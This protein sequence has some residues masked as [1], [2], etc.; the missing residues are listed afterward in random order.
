MPPLSI[1]PMPGRCWCWRGR[2]L[3]MSW[4]GSARLICAIM[5]SSAAMWPGPRWRIWPGRLRAW[6]MRT[7]GSWCFAGWPGRWST[8]RR[9]RCDGSRRGEIPRC[10]TLTGRAISPRYVHSRK[11]ETAMR[12]ML[13][14]ALSTLPLSA[15]A[16][17]PMCAPTGEI[18]A[19]AVEARKDG[20]EAPEAITAISADMT[21]GMAP[22]EP[23]VQPLVDWVYTL[24]EAELSKDVEGSYVMQCEAQ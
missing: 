17:N 5:G 6:G 13:I 22:Y 2:G 7:G 10:E 14:A 24:D 21:G 16:Q 20:Q 9:W 19:R 23:A 18:V 11:G 12:L 8:R 4:R 3:W 1:S 15:T